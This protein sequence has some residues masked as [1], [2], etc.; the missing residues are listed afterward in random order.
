MFNGPGE[1]RTDN[2]LP[3]VCDRMLCMKMVNLNGILTS[4]RMSRW[5]ILK[6]HVTFF[7]S[8]RF[9]IVRLLILE[10]LFALS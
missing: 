4:L 9:S 8:L 5:F 6:W 2:T 3:F 1:P 10:M 7:N